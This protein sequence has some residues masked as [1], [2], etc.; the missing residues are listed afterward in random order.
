MDSLNACAANSRSSSV[1]LRGGGR[2]SYGVVEPGDRVGVL[3]DDEASRLAGGDDGVDLLRR[4]RLLAL[5]VL[6]HLYAEEESLVP[7]LA[8]V[9]MPLEPR[10]LLAQL[11]THPR[12]P[13]GQVFSSV[14]SKFLIAAAHAAGWPPKVLTCLSR[15]Y[16]LS[17]AKLSYISCRTAVTESGKYPL[18]MP[19]A[20]VTMSGFTP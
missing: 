13:A 17:P 14:I 20:M 1:R 18:V 12:R 2:Q 19:F 16:S 6:H 15:S 7:D 10:K 3:A 8:H 9:R 4:G 11:L 5:F